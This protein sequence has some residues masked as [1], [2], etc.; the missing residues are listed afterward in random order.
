MWSLTLAFSPV[1]PL[2]LSEQ[3]LEIEKLNTVD[4][5]TLSFTCA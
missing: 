1:Y 2:L 4:L 3:K 5:I